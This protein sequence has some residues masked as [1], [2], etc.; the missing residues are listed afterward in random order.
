MLNKQWAVALVLPALV[1]LG[2]I[3]PHRGIKSHS[4]RQIRNRGKQL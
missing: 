2:L 3:F 4:K 1:A